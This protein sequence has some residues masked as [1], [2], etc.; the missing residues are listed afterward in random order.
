MIHRPMLYRLSY[1]HQ[2][3]FCKM[4]VDYF[5]LLPRKITSPCP[6]MRIHPSNFDRAA[7]L[8]R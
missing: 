1:A 5:W 7:R 4:R 8:F 3:S 2:S 6:R